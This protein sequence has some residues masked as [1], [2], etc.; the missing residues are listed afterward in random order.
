LIGFVDIIRKLLATQKVDL[1]KANQNNQT[2]LHS[3]METGHFYCA[4]LLIEAK[5]N[6]N[7][8]DSTGATPVHLAI[9]HNQLDL[10]E[11]MLRRG[12]NLESILKETHETALLNAVKNNNLNCVKLLIQS[13]ASVNVIDAEKNT[14]CH[15]AAK[16]GA[17]AVLKLILEA[18]ALRCINER[19]ADGLTAILIATTSDHLECVKLLV[20]NDADVNC[21]EEKTRNTSFHIAASKGNQSLLEILLSS[22]RFAESKNSTG[23]TPLSIFLSFVYH[24]LTNF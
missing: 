20:D 10:L 19:N 2:P 6:L 17:S 4:K 1:E 14:A 24:T 5:A 22:K 15:L 7:K 12:A 23:N 16:I 21:K 8:A 3:A 11:E 9:E 18:P 13:N